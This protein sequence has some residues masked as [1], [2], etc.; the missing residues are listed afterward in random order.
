[1]AATV[2]DKVTI[3]TNDSCLFFGRL[4]QIDGLCG[5]FY[6]PQKLQQQHEPKFLSRNPTAVVNAIGRPSGSR[7]DGRHLVFK[8][9]VEI[10]SEDCCS[11]RDESLIPSKLRDLSGRD[12]L[13]GGLGNTGR[14]SAL[15]RKSYRESN[16]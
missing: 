1:M 10:M 6:R 16:Q 13:F 4:P 3:F 9:R 5:A 7:V 12:A 14:R 2:T 15:A 11:A 8:R